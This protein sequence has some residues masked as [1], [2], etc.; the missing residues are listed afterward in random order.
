MR[1][2]GRNDLCP[3]GSG[4]KYK[5]CCLP[6]VATPSSS[7]AVQGGQVNA[8]EAIQAALQHHQA[9]RLEQAAEIYQQVLQR[10]PENADALHLL[11]LISHQS[12]QPEAAVDLISRAIQIAPSTPL[13][14]GNIGLALTDLGYT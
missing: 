5:K 13:Y 7:A 3:C 14:Y 10:Q 8:N 9:G 11:G 6:K 4:K 12:G 1:A 2:L